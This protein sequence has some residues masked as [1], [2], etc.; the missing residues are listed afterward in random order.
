MFSAKVGIGGDT[1]KE[2]PADD[3]TQREPRFGDFV[4]CTI[5]SIGHARDVENERQLA[6]AQQQL[7]I[8]VKNQNQ[9]HNILRFVVF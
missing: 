2:P 3:P 5:G 7:K 4:S 9:Q 6:R 1:K 8:N